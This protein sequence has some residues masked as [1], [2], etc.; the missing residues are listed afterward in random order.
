[1]PCQWAERPSAADPTLHCV[2]TN[3][4]AHPAFYPM[5][6][7]GLKGVRVEEPVPVQIAGHGGLAG[8]SGPAY[9]AFFIPSP[10]PS[11]TGSLSVCLSALAQWGGGE[12]PELA[13]GGPVGTD[14]SLPHTSSW[15]FFRLN[16][17]TSLS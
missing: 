11:A 13:L 3:S 9:V 8:G 4:R 6:T 12:G 10:I 5:G 7:G 1:M 16:R 17:V 15:C 14:R 2:Q